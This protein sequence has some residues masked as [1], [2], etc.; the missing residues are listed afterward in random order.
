[1]S[2]MIMRDE[3][4]KEIISK[5]YEN[6]NI[7]FVTADFGSPALDKLR[8]EFPDRYINVG[9]AEQNLINVTTGLALEGAI[10]YAYAIAPF[11][12]MRC[13]E[14]IRI[15]LAVLAELRE[16]N[17]NLIGVGAGF[18][19]V[20]SGP[21]H[22]ALEDISIM[23]TLPNMEVISPCDWVTAKNF[24]EYSIKKPMPKYLRLD[25]M[26]LE[27]IYE[28]ADS[29]DFKKGFTE[30]VSG[31]KV[32]L[33]STGYMTHK[34]HGIVERLNKYGMNI[35][36]VDVFKLSDFSDKDLED[37]LRKYN[38]IITMEEGFI[39]KGGLDSMILHFINNHDIDIKMKSFGLA[40]CY[41]FALGNREDLH[42]VYNAS[43]Q[44]LI[45]MIKNGEEKS[46]V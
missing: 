23:R 28:S 5:M 20:C 25:G 6:D 43:E 45:D 32:C 35:G 19:Y 40:E 9:I 15:N 42:A 3:V 14:Q 41:K 2:S 22:Q 1:M 13:Y 44:E 26:K 34:A 16:I 18:S 29:V 12:S 39:G 33:F 21:S 8:N 10:V 38:F 31:D 27:Q 11:I 36:L 30:I 46:Y 37:V 24:V 4:I 17:V 7:Y